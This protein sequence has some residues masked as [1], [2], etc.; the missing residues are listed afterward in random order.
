[1]IGKTPLFGAR[2]RTMT[3]YRPPPE[4]LGAIAAGEFQTSHTI[5]FRVLRS[6]RAVN[7]I[8][9]SMFESLGTPSE[10]ELVKIA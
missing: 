4:S 3:L 10:E 9:D 7:V 1:M 5:F 8:V 6:L 2:N